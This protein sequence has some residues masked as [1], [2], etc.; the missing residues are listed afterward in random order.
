MRYFRLLSVGIVP[1]LLG[2]VLLSGCGQKGALY[3]PDE[4][5]EKVDSTAAKKEG[6]AFPAAQVQK[7]KR[8]KAAPKPSESATEP[9]AVDPDRP[10]SLPPGT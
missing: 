5:G 9:P 7:E 8:R 3:R 6:P 2:T 1:L 4:T 10:A